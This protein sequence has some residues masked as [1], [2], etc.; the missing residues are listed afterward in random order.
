MTAEQRKAIANRVLR[1]VRD[2][3]RH[4]DYLIDWALKQTG[5]LSNE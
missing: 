2:G 1:E 5:D 3:I 4:P